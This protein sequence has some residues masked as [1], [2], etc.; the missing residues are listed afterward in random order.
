MWWFSPGWF[1]RL[2]ETLKKCTP[3]PHTSL[4][5]HPAR[6]PGPQHSPA[7]LGVYMTHAATGKCR[8]S[9][10]PRLTPL[11]LPCVPPG[12]PSRGGPPHTPPPRPPATPQEDHFETGQH[13]HNHLLHEVGTNKA[14]QLEGVPPGR[15]F[16]GE[17]V[18]WVVQDVPAGGSSSAGARALGALSAPSHHGRSQ[19]EEDVHV[20]MTQDEAR[21]LPFA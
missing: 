8:A 10:W 19:Q 2:L 11:T 4:T 1:L 15:L 12:G 3:H 6:H 14:Y 16:F 18:R 17:Y 5:H 9:T 7:S 13:F 21:H 20:G